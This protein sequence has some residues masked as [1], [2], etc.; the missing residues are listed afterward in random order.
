ML[1]YQASTV[2]V[3]VVTVVSGLSGGELVLVIGDASSELKG[4]AGGVVL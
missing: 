1:S 4:V 2:A 3:G